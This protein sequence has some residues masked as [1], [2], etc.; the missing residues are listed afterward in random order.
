LLSLPWLL[1]CQ[2]PDVSPPPAPAPA[3]TSGTDSTPANTA[4]T[5]QETEEP[6]IDPDC[7]DLPM[8]PFSFNSTD[9]V[10]TEE[11]F[12]FDAA[13]YLLTQN[14]TSLAGISRQGQAHVIAPSIGSDAAGIRSLVTGDIVVAQPDTG[15]LRRVDYLTGTTT[16]I[17]SGL[18][19]PNGI[20]ASRD[21]MIYSSEYVDGGRIRVV[22]PY[23]GD[24]YVIS[25]LERPNNMALTP[26]EQTL[27]IV[28]TVGNG[29][30]VVA[31]D[32]EDDGD[33]DST[34]RLVYDHALQLGGI[35]TDKCGNVY[36]VEFTAGK[37]FRL[38]TDS[39][40]TPEPIVDLTSGSF[41]S[42]RFSAG[43]DD[44][45]PTELFVTNRNQLFFL[46]VGI[47]GR[48]VLADD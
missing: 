20:E 27:Y 29:S 13:G 32:R 48:H 7:L 47:A 17:L 10:H 9:A 16:T 12:D 15:S 23:S 37:V 38:R 2:E 26:D 39:L 25:Q 22:D 24:A 11:D 43:K 45:S 3:P 30:R 34:P 6:E 18:S 21:G 19:F 31:L 8:G 28:T 14:G 4:E 40:D 35:T 41:S 1:A 33:W 5:G 42:L 36:I 46:D 44:W